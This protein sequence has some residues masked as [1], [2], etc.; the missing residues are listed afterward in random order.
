M[1]ADTEAGATVIDDTQA[2]AKTPT[3]EITFVTNQGKTVRAPH[4]SNLLRVSLRE[5]GG[6]PFKC[7]G[8]REQVGVEPTPTHGT[9]SPASSR[10]RRARSTTASTVASSVTPMSST[11]FP[12][13]KV[14]R[15]SGATS[16]GRGRVQEA[17]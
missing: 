17:G 3:V 15:S 13:L 6:I 1:M 5:Q 7:G 14:S 11:T 2:P 4:N 10:S 12:T 9:T 8:G 16:P